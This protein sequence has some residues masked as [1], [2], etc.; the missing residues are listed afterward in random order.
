MEPITHLMTVACLARAGFNRKAAYTTV[1]MTLAAELPDLDT[2]WSIDGPIA[3]FQHH[4][5]WTH[6]FLSIPFEAAFVIGAIWLFHRWRTHRT[7]PGKPPRAPIQWG[8]L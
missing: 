6:A 4:R 5:G 8:L 3:G 2:L 7:N 1:A